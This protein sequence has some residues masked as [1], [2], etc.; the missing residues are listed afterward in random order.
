MKVETMVLNDVEWVP[1]S[2]LSRV[3]AL[4][5][6]QR[7]ALGEIRRAVLRAGEELR[8]VHIEALDDVAGAVVAGAV[9]EWLDTML[10]R[11]RC[12]P[13]GSAP[14]NADIEEIEG[15]ASCS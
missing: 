5:A 12:S 14:A 1:K 11:H 15:P 8:H 10:G 7:E 9:G 13:V 6:R 4:A 3:L 2:E